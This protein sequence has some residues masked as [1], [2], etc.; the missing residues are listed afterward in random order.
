MRSLHSGGLLFRV[1][2]FICAND[3]AAGGLPDVRAYQVQEYGSAAIEN[4][5]AGAENFGVSRSTEGKGRSAGLY[6]HYKAYGIER[7]HFDAF[8][9]LMWNQARR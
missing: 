8:V 6:G 9:I 5:A 1:L 7:W 4:A 3:F 2:R